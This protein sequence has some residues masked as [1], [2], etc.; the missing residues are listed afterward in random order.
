MR[1]RR[2]RADRLRAKGDPVVATVTGYIFA[3]RRGHGMET[4]NLSYMYGG[5]TYRDR[6]M[7][8]GS[9]NCWEEPSQIRIWV[10]PN[11]PGGFAAENG[12]TD[13]TLIHLGRMSVFPG[14]VL[15]IVAG[16]V[17]TGLGGGLLFLL[18]KYSG[19]GPP[20]RPRRR[21]SATSRN[22]KVSRWGRGR[23]RAK[24]RRR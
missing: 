21:K 5:H 12:N 22:V 3:S 24:R 2:S 11:D 7:C 18:T 9:V 8:G 20:P 10:D 6:I 17:I 14:G 23:S 19:A 13:D 1:C 16:I 4:L 15:F